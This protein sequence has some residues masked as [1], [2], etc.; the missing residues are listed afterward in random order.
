M[1]SLTLFHP[2]GLVAAIALLPFAM[3]SASAA[4]SAASSCPDYFFLSGNLEPNPEFEIPQAGV[5]LGTQTCWQSGDLPMPVAAAADW[6][7]HSN[8]VGAKVCST[9]VKGGRP[10]SKGAKRLF[11]TAGG[12]EGGVYRNVP[13]VPGK[14]YMFS[15]WVYVKS[16]QVAIQS[17]ATVGG[18][19]AWTSKTKEWEQLRVC[20][21]SQFGADQLVI[22]N[23]AG[24]G[25]KF[26]VD[27]AEFR[28]IPLRE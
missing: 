26:Y 13:F 22:Y 4:S 27:G 28:E 14:G 23:Q 7:M 10:G 16:G 17:S 21:N 9:I 2:A 15:V 6:F 8:N 12:N 5:P 18:P 19:V 1:S 3:A 24:A 25:G 11:V 20:N